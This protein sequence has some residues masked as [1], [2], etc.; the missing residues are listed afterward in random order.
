M[1]LVKDKLLPYLMRLCVVPL[2]LCKSVPFFHPSQFRPGYT[3]PNGL[4]YTR[5]S[6]L[7]NALMVLCW[8]VVFYWTVVLNWVAKRLPFS[9]PHQTEMWPATTWVGMMPAMYASWLGRDDTDLHLH[10]KR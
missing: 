7:A 1:Y 9:I 2:Y 8:T 5:A 4:R 10:C 3:R 6:C